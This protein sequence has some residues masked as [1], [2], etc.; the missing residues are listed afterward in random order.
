MK[1]VSIIVPVYNAEKA[2]GRCVESI[3]S[4]DYTELEV[5]LVDDGSRDSSP[6][7]LDGFAAKDPR[8]LCIHKENGGVSAARNTGLDRATGDYIQFCDADDWLAPEATKLLVRRAE[9]SAADLVVG[10]FYRVVGDKVSRKGSIEKKD[11]LT[12]RQYADEMLLSPADLYYGVL[13]NKLYRRDIIEQDRVRMD[14]EVSYSEDMIFNLDYLKHAQTVAVLEAPVYYYVLTE[15]SLVQQN[16]NIQSTVQMKTTV[17]RYYDRFFRE[18]FP[19]AEYQLRR[20]LIYWY[21]LAVSTDSVNLPV[22]SDIRELG[23]ESGGKLLLPEDRPLTYGMDLYYRRTVIS[24]Y[25]NTVAQQLHVEL[26]EAWILYYLFSCGDS[27]SAEQL[28]SYTG[29]GEAKLRLLLAKL[30]LRKLITLD[31]NGTLNPRD[32]R[33]RLAEGP[34]SSL[35]SRMEE[36]LA[37][38]FSKGTDTL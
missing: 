37:V 34:A 9:D 38:R 18:I 7:I 31:T 22:V 19:D 35:L 27:C 5:I 6:E 12:L 16:L 36:D 33:I 1:K 24:R 20:P 8:V 11:I 32:D 23:E 13:W 29:F 4:Q 28:E 26:D 25:L 17:I 15:G 3:L 21:L 30:D 10:D 14:P 2:I